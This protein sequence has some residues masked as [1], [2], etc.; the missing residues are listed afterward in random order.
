LTVWAKNPFKKDVDGL[1][2]S[3]DAVKDLA[4]RY[5]ASVTSTGSRFAVNCHVPCSFV[6]MEK[7]KIRYVSSSK[8]LREL[9]GWIEIGSP[10]PQGSVAHRLKVDPSKTQD[11]DEIATD[12][13]FNDSVKGYGLVAEETMLLREWDQC[14]SLIWFDNDLKPAGQSHDY[15]MEDGEPLLEELDGILPWP[16]KS[17]RK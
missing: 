7:G 6:L 3:L 5:K 11:Y 1:D 12:I 2:I 16:S 14:L 17:R 15:G 10:V 9:K 13:W 8:Y 4:E